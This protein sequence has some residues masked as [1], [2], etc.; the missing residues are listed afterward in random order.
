MDADRMGIHQSEDPRGAAVATE[1]IVPLSTISKREV[2]FE[3]RKSIGPAEIKAL[4]S[5]L[6]RR[7]EGEVRFDDG[8][9]AIYAVDA[10][11]YRQVPIGVVIPKTIQDVIDT[12][13][14]CREFEAPVLS[15]GGGTSLAGQC[16]NVAIVMDWTKYLHRVIEI[17][18]I[19]RL[20]RVQPGCVLDILQ[21][22]ARPY[23]LRFGPDP[24][25]HTRCTL[26]GMLGN[27]SCGVHAQMNGA[28][29]NNTESM[30]ILLYDGT[31]MSVGW[32]SVKEMERKIA[33]GGREGQI[34][35]Q[36]RDLR[37]R[38]EKRIRS[39]FPNIPRRI[40]GY[41]LDQLIPDE[42]GRLNLARA[43]IGSEGT[44]VTILEA[45]LRLIHDP[46]F[47]TLVVLGYPDIYRAA[48]GVPEVLEA[49]PM[50]LEG[51]DYYLV[52]CMKKQGRHLNALNRLPKGNGWL[53]VQ[54]P[55]ETREEADNKASEL[56][57]RLK[58]QHGAP[59]IRCYDQPGDEKMVWDVREAGQ[60]ASTF[61]PG[62]PPAWQGWEDAAVPPE[63]L[64]DYLRD[65]CA[66]LEKFHYKSPLY[67]HFGQG[68]VHTAITFDLFTAEGVKNYR[69]FVEQAADLVI[70]YGGS[71][72]G[73]HGDGQ[74]RAELLP[75]MFGS[76]LVEAFREFKFIWDPDGK[77]NPGKIVD[78]YRL[79]DNLR[80]GPDYH[81]AEPA[82][83]FRYPDDHGSFA[84]ATMR[85]V[86][87]G[88]CRRLT[89]GA[90]D[91]QT[92]C[93]SYMVT[94]E[95][96]HSTRGRA[97]LL[98]EMLEGETIHKGW[99]NENV[100]EA[101]DLCLSCKG[102]KGDCPVNVDM[103]TYKAEFLSHYW[104]GRLR[105]RSAYAFG[106]IDK[107]A[108]IASR[109]AGFVNLLTGTPGTREVAKWL[110]GVAP[111][112]TI[113]QFAPE[114]FTRWFRSRK[115]APGKNGKRVLLFPDTFNNYFFPQ[116]ARAAVEVLEYFGYEVLIPKGH[117][118]CG[119]PLYDYGFLNM[120]RQYLLRII[121]VLAPARAQGMPVVVLEPSC[122]S[123]M[124][125]EINEMLP[126][127]PETRRIMENTF[128]LGEF[129]EK[130]GAKKIPKLEARAIFHA[131]CHHKAIVKKAEP[132]LKVLQ[133]MGLDTKELAS[134]C[135][136]MAGS[137]G[138]ET[139]KYDVSLK[140]GEH[141]LL[142]EVRKAGLKTILIA[143]G[144]S[145]REQ[146]S[147]LSN[148]RALHLAEVLK[149]AIDGRYSAPDGEAP[150]WRI[151]AEQENAHAR[152]SRDAALILACA[153]AGGAA[154][155]WAMRNNKL[156]R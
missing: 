116:T 56:M 39:R 149:L 153:A 61:V 46:P 117:V 25:T 59:T 52:E 13:A 140:V 74:S 67:G 119:R 68:C 125:D 48:D 114:P 137:F 113:P 23:G 44:L 111:E 41:N 154:A 40:S 57:R 24:A 65:F 72:S 37:L 88:K 31:R 135:C 29:S 103:A 121:G 54:L 66:L 106:W 36:L 107:W 133:Q 145:C 130:H 32:T 155:Y 108:Q 18:P 60:G 118:C 10:S 71:L 115:K 93:P 79:D 143:D 53:V 142:P 45:T 28:V 102:C 98:W 69:R 42:D 151:F 104:E 152:A 128:L 146:I 7:I 38:Y 91:D 35:S 51:V 109:W 139:D 22:R 147:Q 85:C 12:I 20:A 30:E 101:L 86:G 75:K 19:R 90:P 94:R 100:K 82:T 95:E 148:R 138:F 123:V 63:K 49:N 78:A 144:F 73:E 124:R 50:G 34:M 131:H 64:G 8:S 89:P 21:G 120:A 84:H 3:N 16:C 33:H 112:R 80:L 156:G 134:G 15:R 96:K 55:G 76:E 77:M 97:H 1:T 99:R 150:E 58:R 83:H 27:N 11:N 132:E 43:L 6:E 70:S 14:I 81:P 87:L 122:W 141:T 5:E 2:H 110:A 17:D 9:R 92:I 129:I 105:P 4:K 62:E 127:H 136:G 26:G 47:Q 126:D